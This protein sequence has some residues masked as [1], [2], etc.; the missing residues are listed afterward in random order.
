[1]RKELEEL[2]VDEVKTLA[3][4]E[5]ERKHVTVL[6]SDLSGYTT[7]TEKLDPDEV[8]KVMSHIFGEI[9]QIV[10]KYEG[11]IERFIGDAIMAI[12]GFPKAHEYDPLRAIRVAVEIYELVESPSPQLFVVTNRC[13]LL[14]RTHRP[15]FFCPDECHKPIRL[16]I[17]RVASFPWM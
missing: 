13:I 11:F 6:F 16:E 9:A 15:G 8:K 2:S 1:M 12:F 14:P 3:E 17:R 5:A 10:T 7:I 4:V